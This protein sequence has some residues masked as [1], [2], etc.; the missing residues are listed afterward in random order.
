MHLGFRRC[1][2][3]AQPLHHWAE[4]KFE[5]HK[6]VGR[7]ELGAQLLAR[8]DFP[9]L[10]QNGWQDPRHIFIPSPRPSP[11]LGFCLVGI[12]F[13]YSETLKPVSL[14]R[15]RAD[16]TLSKMQAARRRFDGS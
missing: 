3:V 8:D 6:R 5:I 12:A 15:L 10:F 16:S 9:A 1:R 13:H 14:V 4:S 7:A 11:A 2:P